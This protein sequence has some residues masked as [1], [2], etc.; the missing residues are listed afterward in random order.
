MANL[1]WHRP[2]STLDKHLSPTEQVRQL[3]VQMA[4]ATLV[5]MAIGSATRVMNAGLA[6]PD[7]PLCYGVLV[8][9]RQMNLQVFLEWFHRLDA[10][11]IGMMAIVLTARCWW[12]RQQLPAWLPWLATSV[13]GL[14]LFQGIL[15]GLTVVELLRF[16]IVTAHLG[17]AQAIFIVL[18]VMAAALMPYQPTGTAGKLP[19]LSLAAAAAVYGQSLS[20]GLVA[21]RWALH[22]C[23]GSGELCAVMNSHVLGVA[24]P[25][26]LILLLVV[27][28]HRTAALHPMLRRL[29]TAAVSLLVL[30]VALGVATFYL[31]LQVEPLTVSHHTIAAV[32]LGV[33]ATF[34]VYAFRDRLSPSPTLSPVQQQPAQ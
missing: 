24:L 31:H 9:S 14:I 5:L 25:V 17:T 26:G 16:D 22:Q 11:L 27:W 33:L 6:C 34:T 28:A 32:L 7:W 18:T 1:A 30:Q 10:S 13:L 29:A 20:G 3:A 21:S 15:G 4:I 8:P 12:Q 19:W 23:F 2:N